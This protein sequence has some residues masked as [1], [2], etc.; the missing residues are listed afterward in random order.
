[1]QS[2]AVILPPTALQCSYDID[3]YRSADIAHYRQNEYVTVGLAGS[4]PA[5]SIAMTD[6]HK[7][8]STVADPPS[9]RYRAIN[10][11]IADCV[12]TTA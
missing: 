12:T 5:A 9:Y 11:S 8:I 2:P 6:S 1:M 3:E 4:A 10:R 7:P